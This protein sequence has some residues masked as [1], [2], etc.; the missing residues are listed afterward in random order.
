MA[1]LLAADG[2]AQSP[3]DVFQSATDRRI[4]A[5]VNLANL[6]A[7]TRISYVRYLDGRY[8]DTRTTVLART[9]KSMY[10]EFTALPGKNFTPGHYRLRLYVNDAAA[11]E[12]T[13]Q[14][15]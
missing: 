13:Y 12:T 1:R 7:R 15:A 8:V 3:T 4:F 10:F 5:V 11:W 2:S 14:I 9:S 6:P